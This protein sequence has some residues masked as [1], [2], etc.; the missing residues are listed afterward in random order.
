GTRQQVIHCA[1]AIPDLP[2]GKVGFCEISQVAQNRV[3]GADKVVPAFSLL[4]VP[5][6]AAFALPHGI[7]GDNHISTPHQALREGL[8]VNFS[9]CRMS[10]RHKNRRMDLVSVVRNVYQRSDKH[11]RQ[12][13]KDQLLDMEAIHLNLARNARME[14]SALFR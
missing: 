1:Y 5:E 6:L 12:T 14:G 4:R 9:I 2:A 3:L 7:P 11:S 8:I 10:T 13:F